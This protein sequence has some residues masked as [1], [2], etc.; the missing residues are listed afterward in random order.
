MFRRIALPI[1]PARSPGPEQLHRF[2]PS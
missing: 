2:P 1:P